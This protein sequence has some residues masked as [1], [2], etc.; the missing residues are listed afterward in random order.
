MMQDQ[1]T[2]AERRLGAE[3]VGNM[4]T[5]ETQASKILYQLD[6]IIDRASRCENKLYTSVTRLAGTAPSTPENGVG[7]QEEPG[8]F[9]PAISDK[10]AWLGSLLQSMEESINRLQSAV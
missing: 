8:G 5:Q 9:I 1:K 4:P 7:T 3:M 6:D 10:L 2:E